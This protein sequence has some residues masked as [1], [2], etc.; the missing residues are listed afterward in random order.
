M[1]LGNQ[2]IRRSSY[3][4]QPAAASVGQPIYPTY[5]LMSNKNNLL[6]NIEKVKGNIDKFR[7]KTHI[8]HDKECAEANR[9]FKLNLKRFL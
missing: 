9:A 2:P 1:K 5:W 8:C 3:C 7:K 6:I 4:N